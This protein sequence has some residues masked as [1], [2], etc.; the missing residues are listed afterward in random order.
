MSAAF[1]EPVV[2][3]VPAKNLICI[4]SI[5]VDLVRLLSSGPYVPS[6]CFTIWSPLLLFPDSGC[7]AIGDRRPPP[8]DQCT[9]QVTAWAGSPAGGGPALLDVASAS[10][11]GLALCTRHRQTGDRDRLASPGIPAVLELEEPPWTTGQAG[12]GERDSGAH[13]KHEPGQSPLGRIA[14]G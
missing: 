8:S 9:A 3:P 7:P 5:E 12:I 4:E 2:E 6:V 10:L 11:V 13:S 14:S 1:N